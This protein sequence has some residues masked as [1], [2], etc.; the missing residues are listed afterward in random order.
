MQITSKL[1]SSYESGKLKLN[2]EMGQVAQWTASYGELHRTWMWQ[3]TVLRFWFRIVFGRTEDFSVTV[4]EK[5]AG[6]EGEEEEDGEEEEGEEKEG[7]GEEE[8]EK[9]E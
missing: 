7:E 2:L 8:E 9:E 6:V 3:C 5:D 4:A 1:E